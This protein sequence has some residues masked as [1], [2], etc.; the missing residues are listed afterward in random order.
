MFKVFSFSIGG[1]LC[2]N[3]FAGGWPSIFYVFGTIGIVW[4][5]LWL[6][7]TSKSPADHHF[8]SEKEREYVLKNTKGTSVQ[9]KVLFD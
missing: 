5:I 6:S 7:L 2:V 8:I 1:Y 9:Q 4:S 3:G